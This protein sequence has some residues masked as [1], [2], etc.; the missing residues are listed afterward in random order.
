LPA[1]QPKAEQQQ[2]KPKF[3]F[4]Y[5]ERYNLTRLPPEEAAAIGKN[6]KPRDIDPGSQYTHSWE[7][8]SNVS[9]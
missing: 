3:E 1:I 2:P 5:S 9:A 6:L 8:L 7:F 4:K